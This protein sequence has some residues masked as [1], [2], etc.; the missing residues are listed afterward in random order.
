MRRRRK[1]EVQQEEGESKEEET[2]EENCVVKSLSCKKIREIRD[3]GKSK[4]RE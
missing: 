3:A 4:R 1:E 2:E